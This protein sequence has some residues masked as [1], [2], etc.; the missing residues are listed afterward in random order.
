MTNIKEKIKE[1]KDKC[2]RTERAYAFTCAPGEPSFIIIAQRPDDRSAK[3]AEVVPGLFGEVLLSGFRNTPT[4]VILKCKNVRLFLKKNEEKDL[5]KFM[6]RMRD[7]HHLA[8]G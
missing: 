2:S 1:L 6:H 4:I 8:E 3:K 7:P 5:E